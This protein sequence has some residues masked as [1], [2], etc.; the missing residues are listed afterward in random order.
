MESVEFI[1]YPEG[2]YDS[3]NCLPIARRGMMATL[4]YIDYEGKPE[5]LI[6]ATVLTGSSGSPVFMAQPR[7]AR[8][9]AGSDHDGI[10]NEVNW[11]H[12]ENPIEPEPRTGSTRW[13][14]SFPRLGVS[15]QGTVC[16]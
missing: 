8:N 15:D 13:S 6:D 10:S 4:G 3:V 1:G 12:R 7:N 2:L 9:G 16:R 5:F 14:K 11:R